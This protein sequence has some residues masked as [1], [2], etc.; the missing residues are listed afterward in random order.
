MTN[1]ESK[2]TLLSFGK[3]KKREKKK[4]CEKDDKHVHLS[5]PKMQAQFVHKDGC[6][7]SNQLLCHFTKHGNGWAQP[8]RLQLYGGAEQNLVGLRGLERARAASGKS[9]WCE[10]GLLIAIRLGFRHS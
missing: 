10:E 2:P 6:Y 1:Q 7:C 4:L 5:I 8:G 3:K 9:Y